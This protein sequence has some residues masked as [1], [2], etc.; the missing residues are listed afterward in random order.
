M[1]RDGAGLGWAFA[2]I[3]AEGTLNARGP[4][5]LPSCIPTWPLKWPFQS[6]RSIFFIWLILL[7]L[8]VSQWAKRSVQ[9]ELLPLFVLAGRLEWRLVWASRGLRLVV[10][11]LSLWLCWQTD[12]ASPLGSVAARFTI[13]WDWRLSNASPP[14]GLHKPFFHCK[15]KIICLVRWKHQ[16]CLN[17]L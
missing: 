7:I 4:R 3:P 13:W 14:V 11:A 10:N 2:G 9:L 1:A 12:F 17:F 5:A 8:E 16:G 15:F 6:E